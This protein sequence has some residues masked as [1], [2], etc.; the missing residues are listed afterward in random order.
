MYSVMF[1]VALYTLFRLYRN[2]EDEIVPYS[3]LSTIADKGFIEI[4]ATYLMSL[5]HITALFK[6]LPA[7]LAIVQVSEC[8]Q[9][10]S[11]SHRHDVW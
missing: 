1:G 6:C 9:P 10:T 3:S 8:Y 11:L 2:F 5:F 7:Y 4:V